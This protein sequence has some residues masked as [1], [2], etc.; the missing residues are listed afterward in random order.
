MKFLLNAVAL[1]TAVSISATGQAQ[2]DDSDSIERIEEIVV[3]GTD[4]SRYITTDKG[5]LTGFQLG[6]LESPRVVNIIPEQLVLDQKITDLNEALRNTPGITQ[7]DG[8]GGTNDDFFIRGF[9]RNVVYRDGF[10][11]ATNFKTNLSNVDY[12]QVVRGPAAI[13]YG[14]VEPG[15]LVDI[16][17]KKPLDERRIAG[18]ARVG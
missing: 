15:G 11:R 5:A 16:V 18:E 17:T 10:R 4:Q 9:R 3:V 7:S 13:T 8:F 14:Q 12:T 6:F 1:V 2:V